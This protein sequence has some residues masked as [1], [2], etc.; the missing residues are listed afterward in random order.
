EMERGIRTCRK[1]LVILTPAYIESEWCEI[2]GIMLQTL[3]P[4]NRDLRL[5]PLLKMPCEKPL[6]ISALTH[7]DFT[8]RADF[9]LAWRKLL[10]GLEALPEL[11]DEKAIPPEIQTELD[12]A[13]SFTDADRY[14]EAIPMLEKVLIAADSAGHIV[15]RVKARH[16]LAHAL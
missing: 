15:A 4:A 14:S 13:E 12:R 10:S 11:L 6:R 1:T 7:I 16:K 8:D 5:I 2:E 3:S 9:E